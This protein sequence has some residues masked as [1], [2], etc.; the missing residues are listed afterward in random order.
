MSKAVELLSPEIPYIE[1]VINDR[2]EQGE[3][4]TKTFKLCFDYRAIARAE[5]SIPG[6]DL[7]DWQRWK[8]LKSSDTPK[9][10]HAGLAKFHSDVTL[11]YLLDV[12]NPVAQEPILKAL[13]DYLFPG[14]WDFLVKLK[15]E[16]ARAKAA[17]VPKN[18]LSEAAVSV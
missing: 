6:L 16:E 4:V 8:D 1:L 7:K 17:G 9:L 3:P 2:D 11:E 10:I 5:D 18:E 12:L 13:F 14:L 15:K